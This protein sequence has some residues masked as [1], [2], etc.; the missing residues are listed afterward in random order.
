M[1]GVRCITVRVSVTLTGEAVAD[2]LLKVI[3]MLERP[4]DLLKDGGMD[5]AK[6][7]K[8]LNQ[9]GYTDPSIIDVPHVITNFL[10]HAY[11]DH[12]SFDTFISSCGKASAKLKQTVLACLTP[13]KAVTKANFMNLHSH[14]V[15]SF[16][17]ASGQKGN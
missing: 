16:G 5:L 9:R 7:V 2:F 12:P 8:I 6:S 15:N 17:P 10:K 11:A 3:Q 4:L 14:Y 13:P 1:Q